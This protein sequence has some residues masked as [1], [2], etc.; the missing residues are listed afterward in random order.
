M[1]H[2]VVLDKLLANKKKEASLLNNKASA[3]ELV[4]KL[5]KSAKTAGRPSIEAKK[6]ARNFTVCMA[7][8]YIQFL[9]SF[10][11]PIKKIQ[12]R[13][14][15]LRF[16]IDEFIRMSKRQ[17]GQLK[18]L[19]ESL[20]NLDVVL[21][22]FSTSV[23]KGEKLNLTAKEKSLIDTHV[24]RVHLLAKILCFTPKELQKILP[25]HH[26]SLYSFC[27]NWKR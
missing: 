7:Q 11:P 20:E 4:E 24:S 16:I 15:K 8:G 19:Q 10:R 9:D 18:F 27:L 22:S 12:G 3:E 23:K 26:W 21:K 17:K 1:G 14:R 25:A 6:K 13:G 5:F 2:Q